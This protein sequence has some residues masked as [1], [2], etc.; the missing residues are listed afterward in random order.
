LPR[1]RRALR[2]QVAQIGDA[3]VQRVQ[4]A[5]G[6][7]VAAAVQQ[8]RVEGAE[9]FHIGGGVEVTCRRLGAR[10]GGAEGGDLRGGRAFDE[11]PRH[12]RLQCRADFVDLAGLFRR[13]RGDREDAA[14]AAYHQALG[15]QRLQG[16]P[17]AGAAD[18]ELGYQ[19]ALDQPRAGCQAQRQDRI[20]QG[21]RGADGPGGH[22]RGDRARPVGVV[23]HPAAALLTRSRLFGRPM[24]TRRAR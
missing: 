16:G 24:R 17:H 6:D 15:V 22:R 7:L 13:H 2:G 11:Q 12:R 18:A 3:R 1:E 14:P 10:D 20:A 21:A 8:H 19:F 23:V 5:V 9:R 4:D